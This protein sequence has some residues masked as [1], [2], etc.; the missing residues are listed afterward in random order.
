AAPVWNGLIGTDDKPHGLA[1]Y[2]QAKAL[3]IVFFSNHC[4]VAA[5]YQERL[6]AIDREYGAKGVRLVAIN[7]SDFEQDRLPAMKERAR[8]GELHFPYLFD[9]GQKVAK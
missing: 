2:R 6:K 7:P 5:A 3:V 1:D 4:P 9:A 8:S